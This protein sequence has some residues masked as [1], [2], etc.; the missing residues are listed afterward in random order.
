MSKSVY[1][2][3]PIGKS[4]VGNVSPLKSSLKNR[5][6]SYIGAFGTKSSFGGKNMLGATG[7]FAS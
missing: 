3:T 6:G 5:N 7:Q 1:Q 4:R 2:F